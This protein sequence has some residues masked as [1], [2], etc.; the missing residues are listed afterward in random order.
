MKALDRFVNWL[1]SLADNNSSNNFCDRTIIGSNNRTSV[2]G[3]KVVINGK[4]INIPRNCHSLVIKNDEVWVDGKK[5]SEED[6][7]L[8]SDKVIN[9]VIEGDAQSVKVDNC[10]SISIEGNSVD[11]SSTTGNISVKGSVSGN[12]SSTSG[13]IE[14]GESCKDIYT[15]SGDIDVNGNAGGDISSTSGDIDIRG[16]VEGNVKSTSGDISHK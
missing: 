10:N 14:V 13:D 7:I 8:S 12:I 3:K 5:L 6:G 16:S 9:I 4:T 1:C 2:N 15:N 11:I